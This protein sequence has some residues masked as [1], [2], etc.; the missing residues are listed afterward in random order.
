[1]SSLG[2]KTASIVLERFEFIY[3]GLS[4]YNYYRYLKMINYKIIS[5]V[6]NISFASFEFS[7]KRDEV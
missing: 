4:I 2:E 6:C 7:T 3:L 5:V 1:M